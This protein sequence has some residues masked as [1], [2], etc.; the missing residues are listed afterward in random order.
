VLQLPALADRQQEIPVGGGRLL[1][2]PQEGTRRNLLQ[3]HV[4]VGGILEAAESSAG[5]G[6]VRQHAVTSTRNRKQQGR[7]PRL[8]LC[9]RFG[10]CWQR[11]PDMKG[12]RVPY[13][14]IHR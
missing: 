14:G 11:Q 6:R 13:P 4:Q 3:Q 2:I 7:L 1:C 5:E 8:G 12:Q 9:P 10:Q